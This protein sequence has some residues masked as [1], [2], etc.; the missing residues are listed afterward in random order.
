MIRF[1]RFMAACLYHPEHGFYAGS[2]R[3][4]ARSGDFLTS[5]EVGPLFGAVLARAVD[6]WWHDAGQ[7]TVFVVAEHGAGPGTL[8]AAIRVASPNCAAAL[9]WVMV[10]RTAP[11]RKRH[12]ERLGASTD[13]GD[14]N[15]WGMGAAADG[16]VQ[17]YSVASLPPGID[18]DVVVANELLDNLCVRVIERT[19]RGWAELWVEPQAGG[20][21]TDTWPG[22]EV[23]PHLVDID[24][25]GSDGYDGDLVGFADVVDTVGHQVAVGERIPVH[26]EAMS[27]LDEALGRVRPGGRVVAFDYADD[28]TSMAR[29]GMGE[30]LR[31]YAAHGRGASPFEHCGH[32]DITCDVAT[33]QLA[34]VAEP[35]SDLTQA[36]F[37]TVWGIDALVDEGRRLWTQRASV[38]DL[39]AVAARSRVTEAEALCDPGG[40]GAHRVLEWQIPPGDVPPATR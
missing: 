7:P 38:A 10:E 15:L 4:G 18:V 30:W 29:R 6:Q 39:A 36:E 33:D 26:S 11:Q 12:T 37:L 3:A 25:G 16:R 31:T 14:R 8:A 40:L 20:G 17:L 28:T 1:D 2:G 24:V 35:V 32:Q 21:A 34:L 19:P 27:W 9:R 13:L 5:P 22:T 23:I